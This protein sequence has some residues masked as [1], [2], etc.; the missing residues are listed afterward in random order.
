MRVAWS[1]PGVVGAGLTTFYFTPGT[2]D[3]ADI[4]AFFTAEAGRLPDDVQITVPSSGDVIDPVTG[5]IT[6]TW[7]APGGGVVNGT[8]T[9]GFA[10]GTGYRFV[11]ETAGITRRRHVRGTTYMVPA[12]STVFDTTGRILPASQASMLA[13]AQNLLTATTGT[14]LIWTRP[15]AF[16]PGKWQVITGVRVPENPT[17]L[18]S[19]RS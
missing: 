5:E 11:W 7:T 2:A 17:S 13:S 6:G 8:A 19:R 4:K 14:L 9:T 1:G 10:I 3:P 15:T 18:R 12:A 16:S